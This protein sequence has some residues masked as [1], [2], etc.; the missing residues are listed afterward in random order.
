MCAWVWGMFILMKWLPRLG[1]DGVGGGASGRSIISV[2]AV[3]AIQR[4]IGM[5]DLDMVATNRNLWACLIVDLLNLSMFHLLFWIYVAFNWNI[6]DSN[7]LIW[8]I[9]HSLTKTYASVKKGRKAMPSVDDVNI[10]VN[11]R[12]YSQWGV[13]LIT[14]NSINWTVI[15]IFTSESF[16]WRMV[17]TQSGSP[18]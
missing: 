10:F 1:A 16:W 17:M 6:K 3:A 2:G 14:V 15:S 7:E 11:D 9:E 4:R 12:K 5:N 18:L 8:L 13:K